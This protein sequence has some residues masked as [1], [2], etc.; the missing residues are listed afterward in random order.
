MI[1]I[2]KDWFQITN[3]SSPHIS[4]FLK[5]DIHFMKNIDICF[6]IAELDFITSD[7][8]TNTVII[9]LPE[10][11]Y[12]FAQCENTVF[13]LKNDEINTIV[14]LRLEPTRLIM[15]SFPFSPNSKYEFNIQFFLRVVN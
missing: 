5:K 6:F 14:K 13:A 10:L 8:V 11:T 15:E 7:S 1:R 2:E 3:I 12:K 9:N 4:T